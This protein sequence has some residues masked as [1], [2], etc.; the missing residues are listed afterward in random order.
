[1]SVSQEA[2]EPVPNVICA[3]PSAQNHNM[4]VGVQGA[5]KVANLVSDL[6]GL[7][8]L[9]AAIC[10]IPLDD[11]IEAI[12]PVSAYIFQP[13]NLVGGMAVAVSRTEW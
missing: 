12:Q 1:M 9:A 3:L 2:S 11:L 6:V 5:G 13:G 8:Q 10:W 4:E 7:L